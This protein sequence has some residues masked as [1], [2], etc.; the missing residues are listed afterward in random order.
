MQ[1]EPPLC[2]PRT[3]YQAD[4]LASFQYWY[5]ASVTVFSA[6]KFTTLVAK[7]VLVSLMQNFG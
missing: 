1:P 7:A 5:L 3:A 2:D 6:A 4:A